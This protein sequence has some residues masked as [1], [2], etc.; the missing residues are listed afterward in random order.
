MKIKFNADD[1]LRLNKSIKI[2]SFIIA[3]KAVFHENNDKYYPPKVS[4]DQCLYK[5]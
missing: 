3:V 2:H 5:L 1:D 4:L